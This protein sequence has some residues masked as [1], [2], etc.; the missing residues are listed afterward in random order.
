MVN[1]AKV[2][3]KYQTVNNI[4]Y[5]D[6]TTAWACFVVNGFLIINIRESLLCYDY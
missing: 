2:Y 5:K 1:S 3:N 6:F 4:A